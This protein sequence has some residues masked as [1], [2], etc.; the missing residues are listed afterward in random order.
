MD[1]WSATAGNDA[2]VEV[3]GI[4]ADHASM[5][6]FTSRNDSGYQQ[7][8]EKLLIR[9]KDANTKRKEDGRDAAE[10]A[11]VGHVYRGFNIVVKWATDTVA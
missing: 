3:F 2:G 8:R 9:A 1:Q 5:V 7:L 11:P 10:G 6:K 4:D